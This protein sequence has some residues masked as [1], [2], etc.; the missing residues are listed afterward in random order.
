MLAVSDYFSIHSQPSSIQ[1]VHFRQP[2]PQNAPLRGDKGP[3]KVTIL[4]NYFWVIIRSYNIKGILMLFYLRPYFEG[5]IKE[6]MN[7]LWFY[8]CPCYTE[9]KKHFEQIS[10]KKYE[11]ESNPLLKIKIKFLKEFILIFAHTT[12]LSVIWQSLTIAVILLTT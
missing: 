3:K 1:G 7:F 11:L 4:P 8:W 2:K 10:L 12:A 9:K 6:V 5:N